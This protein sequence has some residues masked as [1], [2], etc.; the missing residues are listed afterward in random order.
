MHMYDF[1]CRIDGLYI[2]GF[3]TYIYIATYNIGIIHNY[4]IYVATYMSGY[5]E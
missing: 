2:D 3:Y 4:I 1:V 5:N